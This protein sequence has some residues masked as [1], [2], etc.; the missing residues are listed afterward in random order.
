MR[1]VLRAMRAQPEVIGAAVRGHDQAGFQAHVHRLDDEVLHFAGTA[2]SDGRLDCPAGRIA[3][4]DRVDLLASL[5][6]HIAH[7][8]HRANDAGL[9][10]AE[11]ELDRAIG[12]GDRLH[13][14]G[15]TG[16]PPLGDGN[17]R[18]FL[19]GQGR[20]VVGKILV[21]QVI[22]GKGQGRDRQRSA[23]QHSEKLFLHGELA[24]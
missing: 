16:L 4:V 5:Q 8:E 11:Q 15:R 7:L 14:G 17:G 3:Q 21:G 23:Q 10:R 9:L 2:A 19:R 22:G 24:S 1:H 6:S 18:L 20:V 13:A 12:A